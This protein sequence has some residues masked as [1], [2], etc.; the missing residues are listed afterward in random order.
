MAGPYRGVAGVDV[1]EAP[2]RDG[3]ARLEVGARFASLAVPAR[4]RLLVQD[5]WLMV[6]QSRWRRRKRSYPL[7]D[8][9][10]W[11]ARGVPGEEVGLWYEPRAGFAVRLLGL[12]PPELRDADALESWRRLDALAGRLRTGVAAAGRGA[13]AAWELG[14]TQNRVLLVEWADRSVLYA[15]PL[16]REL[17]RRVLEVHADGRVVVAGTELACASRYAVTLL[18]DRI[19]F[20]STDE[21]QSVA[22]WLPWIAPEDRRELSVRLGDVIE[23]SK[24]E[25]LRAIAAR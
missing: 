25:Q 13:R 8:R 15:R 24:L 12:R 6:A 9:A 19:R 2:T 4:F 21:R 17:P 7:D 10:L 14:T 11:V 16:F 1:V 5:S 23:R 22:V 18:G 3:I 20:D